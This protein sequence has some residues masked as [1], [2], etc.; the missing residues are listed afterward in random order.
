M[1]VLSVFFFLVLLL[2]IELERDHLPPE[3]EGL[4]VVTGE[5]GVE[6]W[7]PGRAPSGVREAVFGSPLTGQSQPED[8]TR[9]KGPS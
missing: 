3:P 4:R 1:A 5:N 7:W 2:R 8:R 6:V 9:W